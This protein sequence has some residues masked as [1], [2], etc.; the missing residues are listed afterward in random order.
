MLDN[1]SKVWYNLG[2]S[3][4]RHGN[5]SLKSLPCTAC[6]P[7]KKVLDNRKR[8]WY[9]VDKLER[10]NNLHIDNA[11][12]VAKAK[13]PVTTAKLEGQMHRAYPPGLVQLVDVASPFSMV[14][15]ADVCSPPR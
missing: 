1:Q 14:K 15:T 13:L 8:V 3:S 4:E 9:N 11:S 5:N 7:Q 2:K 10:V 12:S 6:E